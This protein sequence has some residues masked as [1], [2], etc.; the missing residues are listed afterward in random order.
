MKEGF[1]LEFGSADALL[2]AARSL[3]ERGYLRL[4]AYTPYLVHG[5]EEALGLSRS[6]IN[7]MAFG[8]T[9][10]GAFGAYLIQWYT[11]AVNYP[12][13]VGGR[14]AHMAPAFVPI[15]F[16]MGILFTALASFFL[17][18]FLSRLPRLWDPI[19]EVEGFERAS[20]DRFFL[21]IDTWGATPEERQKAREAAQ[22]VGAMRVV[23]LGREVS[24]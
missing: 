18:F 23:F 13:N 12:L 5:L 3:R 8:G 4:E 6:R 19:F 17:V 24:P 16:E 21:S 14:P 1:V 7:F 15:T 22:A 20:I 9:L 10:F 2:A 11:N